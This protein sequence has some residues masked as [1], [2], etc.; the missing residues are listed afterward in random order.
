MKKTAFKTETQDT[1]DAFF[2]TERFHENAALQNFD[3]NSKP[4]KIEK[5]LF[6]RERQPVVDFLRQAFLF[7]PGAFFLYYI[8]M[9]TAIVLTEWLLGS[10]DLMFHRNVIYIYLF[11]LLTVFMTWL[12]LGDLKNKK[13]FV[14][15]ASIISAG[16]IIGAAVGAT[17][18][19]FW[20]AK[21]I[22]L[23][24]EY[25]VWLFPIGLIVPFLAKGLIDREKPSEN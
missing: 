8:S 13:H 12:G 6:A 9:G 7:F 2:D 19:I 15:P 10:R 24:F 5:E 21:Q 14:I 11:G 3:D 17:E 23:H 16:A 18:N 20:L 22:S 25:A 4:S 1:F